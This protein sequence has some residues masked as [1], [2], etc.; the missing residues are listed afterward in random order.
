MP[1]PPPGHNAPYVHIYVS[2]G[3]HTH[4]HIYEFRYTHTH[5]Q[6]TQ[7]PHK[8]KHI[9]P[10]CN[11]QNFLFSSISFLKSDLDPLNWI[12]NATISE[13]APKLGKSVLLDAK[14][15]EDRIKCLLSV[16]GH[17]TSSNY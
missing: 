17:V 3:T 12:H 4:V 8:I 9:L 15:T 16:S 2:L 14:L 6:K 7:K 5:K 10:I 11:A 13:E 1:C